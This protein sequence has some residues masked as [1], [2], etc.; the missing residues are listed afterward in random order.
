MPLYPVVP[1]PYTLL[2]QDA[3]YY[4]VLDLKDAFFAYLTTMIANF[5]LLL[6]TPQNLQDN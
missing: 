3:Q 1:N 2:A 5:S 4:S 6:R